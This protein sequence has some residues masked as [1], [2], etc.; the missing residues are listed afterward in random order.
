VRRTPA[1]DSGK[2]LLS[3]ET[4]EHD[5]RLKA[6]AGALLL[7]WAAAA[8]AQT[9]TP[10]PPPPQWRFEM[11]GFVGGSLYVQD[12]NLGPSGGQQALYVNQATAAAP[13]PRQDR[14]VFSG[15]V[16]QSR[17]N[18]SVAGPK[19]W[20][21]ATPKGVLEIDFM[22]GF[23]SGGYGDASLVPR[24]R[25]AY[26]ELDWGN[27]RLQFGQN[28]DLT[29][30][31]APTSLAHIAFPTGFAA[32][33]IGW[34]RPAIWGYHTFGDIKNKEAFK[35]EFAWEVGRATWADN[36][37]IGNQTVITST[38]G[39]GGD[40][41]GF[42]LGEASGLPLVQARL[43]FLAGQMLN[44]WVAGNYSKVDRT[45]VGAGPTT[46]AG[47]SSDMDVIA[48]NAG[49][50]L[51]LGPVTV[52]ATGYTGKNLGPLVGTILQFQ[53]ASKG[54]VHEMGGWAQLGLNF[55][56]QLSAWGMI[57]TAMPNRAD[58][59]NAGL[60]RLQ[61]VTTAALLQYRDG[62]FAVGAEWFHFHTT[63]TQATGTTQADTALDGNQF[64]LTGMYF[65]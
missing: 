36:G 40:I 44:I 22:G 63:Y 31:M 50:K 27:H 39:Q 56:K 3:T 51:V 12:A 32:G 48:G 34:R 47:I 19:V 37:G 49:L 46:V 10:P 35:V 28:N 4:E 7:S 30:A 52:A 58:A 9:P 62:G 8:V 1:L 38:T 53:P 11:H 16:R 57:G 25:L 24:L 14:L 5:V 54:D 41:Y 29:F 33:N 6:L 13:Q 43:T 61:N 15:D 26:A 17:F 2:R 45:G 65:F 20:G 21:G 60:T 42:Q 23:G 64:F 59:I 55:T 18:F